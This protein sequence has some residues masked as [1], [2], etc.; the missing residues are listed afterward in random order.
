M[1]CLLLVAAVTF[2]AVLAA[3][4]VGADA[5]DVYPGEG[6]PIQDAAYG[7]GGADMIYTH[8]GMYEGRASGSPEK[9]HGRAQ[10]HRSRD[11]GSV[12]DN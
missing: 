4:G 5:W 10:S 3:A 1:T 8:G 6:A 11:G 7:A 9:I 2:A 12:R